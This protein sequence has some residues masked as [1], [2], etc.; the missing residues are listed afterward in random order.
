MKITN[1]KIKKIIQ[2][3]LIKNLLEMPV[4]N[5]SFASQ[6]ENQEEFEFSENM[7]DNAKEQYD[8]QL[9]KDIKGAEYI[10]DFFKNSLIDI[11]IIVLP[12]NLIK[13]AFG[14]NI[15]MKFDSNL[16]GIFDTTAIT[17]LL[18]G[19]YKKYKQVISK[20][21]PD[22][23]TFILQ[24]HSLS[25]QKDIEDILKAGEYGL[26][27]G[28]HDAIGHIIQDGSILQ[29]MFFGILGMP[30]DLASSVVGR[31]LNPFQGGD[32]KTRRLHAPGKLIQNIE[33]PSITISGE[34]FGEEE[35]KEIKMQF[36]KELLNFFKEKNF[37]A[38]V[39]YEDSHASIAAYYFVYRELPTPFENPKFM[40]T[41]FTSEEIV[42]FKKQLDKAF[43]NLVGKTAVMNFLERDPHVSPTGAA[44]LEKRG[45]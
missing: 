30:F 44:A 25:G 24:S 21:R 10:K 20:I 19:K 27:W 23:L 40:P 22:A 41:I 12:E 29:S 4:R 2:E 16:I 36:R 8:S 13:A 42:D 7:P 43:Q 31:N 9:V 5:L 15:L 18:A 28:L 1:K 39:G 26:D 6:G 14:L 3:S 17:A 35:N 45:F 33:G 38:S 37:T 32:N 34:R 11:D